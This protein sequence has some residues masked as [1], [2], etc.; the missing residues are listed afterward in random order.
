MPTGMSTFIWIRFR[1]IP[2]STLLASITICPFSDWRD[3]EVHSDSLLVQFTTRN[4]FRRTLLEVKA[5]TGTMIA[6]KARWRRRLPIVDGSFGED[7]VFRYKDLKSWWSNL[8][9]NRVLGVRSANPTEWVPGSKPIRFTEYGCAAVDKGS[10]QP[11]RFVDA[12]SSRSDLPAW[13]NGRRDDLI[14]MQYL[15]A[16]SNYWGAGENNPLSDLYGG[17]DGRHGSCLCLGLGRTAVP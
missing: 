6:R 16:M 14:Q 7:W 13:S 9:H 11:N 4:T 12:K 15:L 8:H 5:S 2:R 1:R 3:G 10:N 17:S